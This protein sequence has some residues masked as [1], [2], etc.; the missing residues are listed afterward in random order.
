[1]IDSNTIIEI[2]CPTK[3]LKQLIES[4]K[5]DLIPEDGTPFLNSKGKNGYYCQV[6][7]VKY[8]NVQC[9]FQTL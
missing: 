8:K 1:M 9:V 4:G 3:P 6:Q 2:K 7:I 5:Y